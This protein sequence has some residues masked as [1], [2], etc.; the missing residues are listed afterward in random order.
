MTENQNKIV[1]LHKLAISAINLIND[2]SLCE[3]IQHAF[4]CEH[5][6][7]SLL[8]LIKHNAEEMLDT[9]GLQ[10]LNNVTKDGTLISDYYEQAKIDKTDDIRD[11]FDDNPAKSE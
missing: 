7:G 3:D 11:Q 1:E 6:I 9:V 8:P 2:I 10:Y 5:L 4:D